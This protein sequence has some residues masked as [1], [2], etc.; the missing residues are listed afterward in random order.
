MPSNSNSMVPEMTAAYDS[1]S[2]G[3]DEKDGLVF[4]SDDMA[5]GQEGLN[6]V[7][8]CLVG[9]FLTDKV[10]N[11]PAMKNTMAALWRPGKGVCIK[12]LS[13]TLFLYQFFHEIDLKRVIDS[14]PWTFDQHILILQRLEE[15]D[16]PHRVPLYHT[17]FW[18]QVYNLLIGFQSEKVLT[19]IGNYIG[20]FQSSDTNNLMGVWRNYMRIRVSIDVWKA[21]KRRLRLKN[22]GE[23]VVL[24]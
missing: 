19:N 18:I 21:L 10:I 15:N 23:G 13:S 6:D 12:D 3:E 14:G 1:L 4:Q 24:G 17:L 20:E 16:K 22:E 11:F 8:F 9:R 5:T 2:I 7:R